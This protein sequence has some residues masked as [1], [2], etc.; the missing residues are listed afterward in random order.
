M[1]APAAASL[2]F[3]LSSSRSAAL[4]AAQARVSVAVE[5]GAGAARA[6]TGPEPRRPVR[7]LDGFFAPGGE[8]PNPAAALAARRAFTAGDGILPGQVLDRSI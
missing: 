3:D 1:I 5:I 2:A 4:R 6:A 7:D 8:L